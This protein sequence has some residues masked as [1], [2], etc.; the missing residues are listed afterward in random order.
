MIELCEAL[1]PTDK[2]R[3]CP[4]LNAEPVQHLNIKKNKRS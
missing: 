3:K 2:K 4:G 1:D